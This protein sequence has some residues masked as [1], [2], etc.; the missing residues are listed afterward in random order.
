MA[1]SLGSKARID[2]RN[3]KY[4]DWRWIW[5]L[6]WHKEGMPGQKSGSQVWVSRFLKKKPMEELETHKYAT[7]LKPGFRLQS[8]LF[9]WASTEQGQ[10]C[11]LIIEVAL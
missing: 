5:A 10:A 6:A 11:G 8:N 3:H 9:L 7:Q 2:M 1:K 4:V